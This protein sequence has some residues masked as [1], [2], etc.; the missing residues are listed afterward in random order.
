MLLNEAAAEALGAR[1]APGAWGPAGGL[2]PAL[3][4]R[5]A[6]GIVRRGQVLMWAGAGAGAGPAAGAGAGAGA[7][8]GTGS[9]S[10]SRDGVVPGGFPDLTGW[11]CSVT[12]L[13]L[14]DFVPVRT[15]VS[16]DGVPALDE[17]VQLLLLQHGFALAT[18]VCRLAGALEPPVPV[19]CLV[20]ANDS[21]ATFRF[22]RMRAGESWVAADLDAYRS[23]KIVTVAGRL[24]GLC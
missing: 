14:E 10:G 22:H 6:R 9:G 8:T 2:A 23:E 18:E 3:A 11:E 16:E 15:T 12:S 21:S 4:E 1:C 19:Q 24:P 17:D 20:S 13:H 5:V 7:G